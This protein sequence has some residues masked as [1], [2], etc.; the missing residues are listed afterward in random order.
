MIAQPVFS[1]ESQRPFGG[2]FAVGSDYVFRGISQTVE[3]PAVQASVDLELQ[4]GVYGYV[5]GSNVDFVPDGEPD[6]GASYEIDIAIGYAGDI[7]DAWSVDVAL[8]R[9]LFPGT[10]ADADYD[11][12]ELITTLEYAGVLST[13]VAYSNDVNGSG[14]KSLYYELAAAIEL[15]SAT[16]LG[17]RVGHYD[18]SDAYDV[19][20]SYSQISFARHF[21]DMMVSLDRIDT[22][23]HAAEIFYD[24]VTGPRLVLTVHYD[25]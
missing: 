19:S 24:Q 16:S 2:S 12:N 3:S 11:F 5:W 14:K 9:Y 13:T 4:S 8:V 22:H 10:H 20:Y 15:G 17:M 18:L 6:D 23:G 1:Q 7:G 21:G 25:W